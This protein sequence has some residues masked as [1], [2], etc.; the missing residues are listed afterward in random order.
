MLGSDMAK[1]VIGMGAIGI[2]IFGSIAAIL[3]GAFT[4]LKIAAILI[5]IAVGLLSRAVKIDSD[6]IKFM[7][8]LVVAVAATMYSYSD[9]RYLV[10][11]FTCA[12]TLILIAYAVPVL[13]KRREELGSFSNSHKK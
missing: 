11:Q 7:T 5:C 12:G 2:L 9:Y 3:I 10:V 4:C 6:W 13:I 1:L 8:W